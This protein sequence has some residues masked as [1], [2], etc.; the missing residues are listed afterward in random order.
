VL[1]KLAAFER[2]GRFDRQSDAVAPL[3]CGPLCAPRESRT[4]KAA[5]EA[6]AETV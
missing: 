1:R 3:V 5:G 6:L 4:Y 2:C